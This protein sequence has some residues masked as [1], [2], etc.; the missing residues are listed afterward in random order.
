M[1][2]KNII[3]R[4]IKVINILLNLG[5]MYISFASYCHYSTGGYMYS[6]DILR[7]VWM[8]AM[9]TLINVGDYIIRKT[10]REF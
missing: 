6:D 9:M 7:I 4:I 2:T 5:M 8:F 10:I 1:K 3:E